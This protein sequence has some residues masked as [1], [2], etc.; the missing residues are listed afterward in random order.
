MIAIIFVCSITCVVNAWEYFYFTWNWNGDNWFQQ[1]C[2]ETYDLMYN[3]AWY[4]S[5][6]SIYVKLDSN[7][8]TYE[9][10]T[11]TINWAGNLFD[12][13]NN[14]VQ[15][16]SNSDVIAWRTHYD[17]AFTSF[18]FDNNIALAGKI[19]S[20]K[21]TP[22]YSWSDYSW[23]FILIYSWDNSD[24][25]WFFTEWKNT[26][27][28]NP[29][30]QLNNLT[31]EIRI[32]RKPCNEDTKPP[33]ISGVNYTS[34]DLHVY[35]H[36]LVFDISDDED[37]WLVPY[38]YNSTGNWVTN[39]RSMNNQIWVNPSSIRVV[40]WWNLISSNDI[41]CVQK[42]WTPKT[43][44]WWEDRDYT[45][46]V[47]SWKLWNFWVE[48]EITITITWADR[49]WRVS[50]TKSITFN[51]HQRPYLQSHSPLGLAQPVNSKITFE[52]RDAWAWVDSGSIVLRLTAS[53]YSRTYTWNISN[54]LSLTRN[55]WSEWLWWAAWYTGVLT[56]SEEDYLPVDS[57]I[58]VNLYFE[59]MNWYSS[60]AM[61]TFHTRQSCAALWCCDWTEIY[62]WLENSYLSFTWENLYISWGNNP[63]VTTWNIEYF[64]NIF[65]WALV[66]NCNY[67]WL[68]LFKWTPENNPTE[69]AS[70][71]YN[72][73]VFTGWDN[74]VKWVLSGNVLTLKYYVQDT[75]VLIDTPNTEYLK[76]E[77]DAYTTTWVL[78]WHLADDTDS[79]Q[80]L[81]GYD[82]VVYSG[83]VFGTDEVMSG[84][85][86]STWITREFTGSEY[87]RWVRAVDNQWNTGEWATGSFKIK[88][89]LDNAS[90]TLNNP[91][92]NYI[93]LG[94]TSIDFD[95]TLNW[96]WDWVGDIKYDLYI[97]SWVIADDNT[98]WWI[99]S[100]S[101]LDTTTWNVVLENGENY[102]WKVVVRDWY[103][104]EIS[105]YT[106]TFKV[107]VETKISR[108]KIQPLN[109][110]WTVASRDTDWTYLAD[111]MFMEWSGNQDSI[112]WS[113]NLVEF[114]LE[115]YSGWVCN[116]WNLI[117][118]G[119]TWINVTRMLIP[120]NVI[121]LEEWEY[122]WQIKAIDDSNNY[123]SNSWL[124]FTVANLYCTKQVSN[125]SLTS[126]TPVNN[127]QL[128]TSGVTL[129]WSANW[130][131]CLSS[132]S[133]YRVEL[134][135]WDEWTI[136][137][138]NGNRIF[139]VT[140]DFTSTGLILSGGKYRWRVQ[141]ID[142][143]E[144]EWKTWSFDIVALLDPGAI[145]NTNF[146]LNLV[147]PVSGTTYNDGNVEFEWY[148][149]WQWVGTLKY[150]IDVYTWELNNTNSSTHI[151]WA[152]DL[153]AT[154]FTANLANGTYWWKVRVSDEYG[155]SG[156]AST[157]YFTVSLEQT[158][159]VIVKT[160]SN[161]K[162]LWY[163]A[164][165]SWCD[166]TQLPAYTWV[167]VVDFSWGI[168]TWIYTGN[169]E[170][171]TYE[172]VF[173]SWKHLAAAL[174]GVEVG[175]ANFD[176]ILDFTTWNNVTWLKNGK[177]IEW[178][179]SPQGWTIAWIWIT[180]VYGSECLWWNKTVEWAINI[181]NLDFDEWKVFMRCDMD[182]SKIVNANDIAQIITNM[183]DEWI[184][185]KWYSWL[186]SNNYIQY[187]DLLN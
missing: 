15:F 94:T 10:W 30:D 115:I 102:W 107:Q 89:K 95:W 161:S 84:R 23:N 108:L 73:L 55:S 176:G 36:D 9:T 121:E 87:V 62:T 69:V 111:N 31:W 130:N 181:M 144:W 63:E 79:S 166:H 43:W 60:W 5:S 75:N 16:L 80:W 19:W 109:I 167:I 8:F 14:N 172:V 28:N 82:F 42:S 137:E 51:T 49:N 47:S 127:A 126:P 74:V 160:Q 20:L 61:W 114:I 22:V 113:W 78:T 173:Q 138:N 182:W 12:I 77:N 158:Y 134:Y 142:D 81:S 169:I 99:P 33:V 17:K 146:A 70:V 128:Y 41:S 171:W 44:T 93:S 149:T 86:T 183:Y 59:D 162:E 170:A 101:N 180:S 67:V 163:I 57:T 46:T 91:E 175:W 150:Q 154:G 117:W 110:S 50:N 100:Q 39:S 58:T 148:T 106:W 18:S 13:T 165:Y 24:T 177:L 32:V 25:V 85:V 76:D 68:T 140:G 103:W 132:T 129:S 56:L 141:M 11:Y 7:K 116:N 133:G 71:P 88:Y 83:N 3:I 174:S 152:S 135:T 136:T 96:V 104:H 4:H 131:N 119:S 120:Q 187:L 38:A 124:S 37:Q 34:G 156:E 90:L 64:G 6:A 185:T 29:T 184:Y 72:R 26:I 112:E 105:G 53:W 139:S 40:V 147:K 157:W 164:F 27:K 178:D 98:D 122:C 48:Q 52:V 66:I 97:Y 155:N 65:T 21:F 118:S 179:V 153:S 143:V 35:K 186:F 125:L 159:T 151:T 1:W 145:I 2:S 45:C 123:S 54:E 168:W 92:N